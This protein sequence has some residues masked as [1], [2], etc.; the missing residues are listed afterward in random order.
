MVWTAVLGSGQQLSRHCLLVLNILE[1]III[2]HI[3]ITSI[4]H[5]QKL[6]PRGGNLCKLMQLLKGEANVSLQSHAAVLCGAYSA[7]NFWLA[8]PLSNFLKTSLEIITAQESTWGQIPCCL[9]TKKTYDS[10]NST[11]SL[12]AASC[13]NAEATRDW[14]PV[15]PPQLWPLRPTAAAGFCL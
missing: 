14:G 5:T 10:A 11:A 9:T 2:L 4:L 7:V 13:Q 6:R 15:T 1:I 12:L 8:L 3:I